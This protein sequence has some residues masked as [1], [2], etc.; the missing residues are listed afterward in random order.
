MIEGDSPIPTPSTWKT[1]FA[2]QGLFNLPYN[3]FQ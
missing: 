1:N 3:K 2:I